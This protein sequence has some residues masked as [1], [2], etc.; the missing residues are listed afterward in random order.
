MQR[1]ELDRGGVGGVGNCH[2]EL[3]NVDR[4]TDE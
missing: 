1:L 3:L 2:S 4:V